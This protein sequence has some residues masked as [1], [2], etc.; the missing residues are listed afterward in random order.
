MSNKYGYDTTPSNNYGE[1]RESPASVNAGTEERRPRG[2][3]NST[4]CASKDLC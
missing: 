1:L 3:E 2:G 4:R